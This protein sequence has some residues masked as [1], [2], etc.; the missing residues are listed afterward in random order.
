[1]FATAFGLIGGIR[2]NGADSF[3]TTAFKSEIAIVRHLSDSIELFCSN[4]CLYQVD[5]DV[6]I[7]LSQNMGVLEFDGTVK[8][9]HPELNH[10]EVQSSQYKPE[11]G[12]KGYL[13]ILEKIT[14]VRVF[15]F[16]FLNLS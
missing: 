2:C 13:S 14:F 15:F 12:T 9:I 3:V 16:F 10:I 5:Q 6:K 11:P 1:M 4:H 7:T 8:D